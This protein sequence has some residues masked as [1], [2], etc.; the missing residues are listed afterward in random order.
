[1]MSAYTHTSYV[2][3]PRKQ[4]EPIISPN[5]NPSNAEDIGLFF[6][7]DHKSGIRQIVPARLK[8]KGGNERIKSNALTSIYIIPG[9]GSSGASLRLS[10]SHSKYLD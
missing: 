4:Y 5:K 10:Q 7:D 9:L 3:A 6:S 2:I 8:L 1:M